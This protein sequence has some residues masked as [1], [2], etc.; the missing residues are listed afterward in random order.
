MSNPLR[1]EMS[2][3]LSVLAAGFIEDL[4]RRGYRPGPAAKQ[5]QAMAHLSRWMAARDLKPSELI[6]A[7]L[8]EFTPDRR[9]CGRTDVVSLK[10]LGPLIDY[11]RRAGVTTTAGAVPR[12]ASWRNASLVKALDADTVAGY[13]EAVTGALPLAGMTLRS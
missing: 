9:A 5:L 7:V 10:G 6:K 8:E 12:P 13:S 4:L 3:P 2:G 1:V 11:L